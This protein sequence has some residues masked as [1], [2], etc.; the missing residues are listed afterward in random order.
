MKQKN[1]IYANSNLHIQ[2]VEI[3][4]A[5]VF[6]IAVIALLIACSDV[7]SDL[8]FFSLEKGV[9]ILGIFVSALGL[10]LAGYFVVLA[11]NAYSH[12]RKIDA[13][14]QLSE[15]FENGYKEHRLR[16]EQIA[17]AYAQ[18]LYDD[19]SEHIFFIG[20]ESSSD[21]SFGSKKKYHLLRR[22]RLSLF[23]PDMPLELFN[24]CIMELGELGNQEDL[25]KL[26]HNRSKFSP[27]RKDIVDFVIEY[28]ESNL[29]AS[30]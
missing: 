9:T 23:L 10:V 1:S 19:I 7:D 30:S 17:N 3:A 11:V 6:V 22:A 4:V 5:I 20:Q 12:V 2:L 14:V 26:K 21:N 27:D 29:E 18:Y 16:M 24:K 25:E 13:L 8:L 15:T 28:M